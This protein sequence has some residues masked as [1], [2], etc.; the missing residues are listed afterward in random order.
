[1][2]DNEQPTIASLPRSLTGA[3][4]R[5]DDEVVVS[6][7]Y[8][9]TLPERLQQHLQET[10]VEVWGILGSVQPNQHHHAHGPPGRGIGRNSRRPGGGPS[11][12][13]S[14]EENSGEDPFSHPTEA[15]VHDG[16]RFR[17]LANVMITDVVVGGR[18]ALFLSDIGR[19]YSVGTNSRGQ[20]GLGDLE[21]RDQPTL[22]SLP[23]TGSLYHSHPSGHSPDTG[24]KSVTSPGAL[25]RGGRKNTSR[26]ALRA[27]MGGDSP[28][29]NS[30][31][32]P[33]SQGDGSPLSAGTSPR[34]VSR[35]KKIGVPGGDQDPETLGP[36]FAEEAVWTVISIAAGDEHSV[37]L[38][39]PTVAEDE[40]EMST[41]TS[42]N[43]LL[44]FGS[45]EA[46]GVEACVEDLL[47]PTLF[48][49]CIGAQAIA[50]KRNQTICAAPA[51]N[52]DPLSTGITP[53]V[54]YGWGEVQCHDSPEFHAEPMPLFQLPTP[55][56]KLCLGAASG[57]ALDS[58]GEVFAWG[59]G[60]YGE[61][62]GAS[63]ALRTR[64]SMTQRQS[65]IG[66]RISITASANL[67]VESE[68]PLEVPGKVLLPAGLGGRGSDKN[69]GASQGPSHMGSMSTV[70][71][72]IDGDA[73]D[74]DGDDDEI[75]S[76]TTLGLFSSLSPQADI[77][78]SVQDR[79][80]PITFS[81]E[82]SAARMELLFGPELGS[83]QGPRKPRV[84]DIAAG[85]RHV[86]ILDD[87]GRLFAFGEN[88][89]GQCGVA[90]AV[91]AGHVTGSSLRRPRLV[92]LEAIERASMAGRSA[93]GDK[94]ARP[95]EAGSRVFA[96]ARHSALITEDNRLYLWG[97]PTNRKLAYAGFN[98]DGTEA[99][100]GVSKE[101]RPAGTAVRS[102]L[103][104]AIRRPRL[105][106]SLLHRRVRTVGLGD[107][108]SII[109]SGDGA[110]KGGSNPMYFSHEP[111]G[112]IWS[113]QQCQQQPN[114]S[115]ATSVG[116]NAVDRQY[117]SG[118]RP[119]L[120]PPRNED[121]TEITIQQEDLT[122]VA[123]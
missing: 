119:S 34:V 88:T 29:Y 56:R 61:L 115:R 92:L 103:R 38:A 73:I 46:A 120:V 111:S 16:L 121:M 47:Q 30:S 41:G 39:R 79:L 114:A 101:P 62:G 44:V 9:E 112:N 24:S 55:V 36:N 57:Y 110:A 18:H 17:N 4:R 28:L 14:D 98:A 19:L 85:D 80:R 71:G 97:H 109:A 10:E 11:V 123:V 84:I 118:D 49:A 74:A 33:E 99:G 87:N 37:L 117:V 21:S 86:L 59:D 5:K 20:L 94:E 90:E 15:A 91:G 12:P 25:R 82:E 45:W 107:E 58:N 108:C 67:A 42:L 100:E 65:H 13:S 102:G 105:V 32:P 78:S 89:A 48:P 122:C 106:Y 22:I 66:G 35:L 75:P 72:G 60:T 7:S 26:M 8:L 70:A 53:T 6:S 104:D 3:L 27:R 93:P 40:A 2:C 81:P 77:T 43:R 83:E 54:I 95:W 68:L 51:P 1:M 113:S 64:V 23:G 31:T 76:E 50:A 63:S 69:T 116:T 96:G 52:A